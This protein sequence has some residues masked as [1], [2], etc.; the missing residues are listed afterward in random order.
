MGTGNTFKTDLYSLFDYYQ[1]T[2]IVHPKELFIETLREFF[3]HDSYYHYVRDEWGFPKTPDHTDLSLDAGL[4]DDQTTRLYIGESYRHDTRY[5]PA[6]IV[7]SGGS[8]S[9]PISINRDKNV[10][11]WQST[12]F[13][14]GYG[15]ESIINTPSCFVRSGAWEG[16]IIVDVES[17]SPRSRD[18]LVELVTVPFIDLRMEDAMV[19][20]V[21]VMKTDIQAPSEIDDR[22]DKIY[23]Q[24]I[25]FTI[26]SEWHREIPVNSVIDVIMICVDIGNLQ[27]TPPELAPNLRIVT[28]VEFVNSLFDI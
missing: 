12:R 3:S 20:G 17:R 21:T 9:V 18:E 13:V 16:T 15:N 19:A 26:R 25:S 27:T 2:I 7:K 14:D 28:N 22:N 11:K 6:L 8:R 4:N 10:V 24:S 1:N 5:Y 23:K